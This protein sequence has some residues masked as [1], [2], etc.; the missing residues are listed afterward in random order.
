MADDHYEVGYGKPPKHS[1]FKP[2][3]SGNRPGGRRQPRTVAEQ[4]DQILAERVSII[5]GGQSRSMTREA[6]LLRQLVNKAMSG[7][8][9]AVSVVLGHLEKRP[10]AISGLGADKADEFLMDELRKMVKNGGRE[11]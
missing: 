5:E 11:P 7:D 9:H 4:F 10:D 8:R 3:Q 6:V 1:Q 2:G